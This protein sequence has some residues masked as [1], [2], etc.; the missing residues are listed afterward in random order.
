MIKHLLLAEFAMLL[1][2][3]IGELLWV[4]LS[5]SHSLDA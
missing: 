2:K 1:Q 4:A 5:I 3:S